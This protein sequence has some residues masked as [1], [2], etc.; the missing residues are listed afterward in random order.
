MFFYNKNY[1]AYTYSMAEYINIF[2]KLGFKNLT[3]NYPYPDYVQ[4]KIVRRLFT[5]LTLDNSSLKDLLKKV[6]FS[7]NLILNLFARSYTFI[8]QK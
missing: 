4:P 5:K 1:R 2:K 8:A 6:Y 7:K 3:A